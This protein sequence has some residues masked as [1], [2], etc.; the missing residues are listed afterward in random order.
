[1]TRE[2]DLAVAWFAGLFEGEGCFAF[3]AK[4][5]VGLQ[6]M[7]TDMDIAYKCVE[8]AGGKVCGPYAPRSNGIKERYVWYLSR[9]NDVTD[10]IN[11]MLPYLGARRSVKA[12]EALERLA[13]CGKWSPVAVC[14]EMSGYRNHLKLKEQPC[15]ACAE[16]NRLKYYRTTAYK[17]R[18][19]IPL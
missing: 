6:I 18:H 2:D 10:L 12:K 4:A 14:G 17:L 16:T 9:K 5:S 13:R 3:H 1:M 19:G 8:V 7:T 11:K 15:V